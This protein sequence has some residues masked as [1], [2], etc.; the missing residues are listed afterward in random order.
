MPELAKT[1]R[2]IAIDLPGYGLSDKPLDVKYDF[3][4][5][6]THSP[7]PAYGGRRRNRQRPPPEPL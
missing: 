7:P 2:V 3:E 1:H 4:F 5:F 6:H